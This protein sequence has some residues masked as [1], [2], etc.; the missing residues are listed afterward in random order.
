MAKKPQTL[1]SD[2]DLSEGQV[3]AGLSASDPGFLLA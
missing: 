1:G 2:P 3:L